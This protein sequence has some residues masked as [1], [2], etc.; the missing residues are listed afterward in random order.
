MLYLCDAYGHMHTIDARVGWE[1]D[2]GRRNE[3]G[4]LRSMH[5]IMPLLF[6]LLPLPM[7]MIMYMP[8]PFPLMLLI[9]LLMM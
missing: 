5:M 7:P 6:F 9:L 8:L 3:R 1:E 4:R 2:G